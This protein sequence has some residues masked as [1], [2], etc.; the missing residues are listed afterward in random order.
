MEVSGQLYAPATL[1]TRKEPLVPIGLEA[2]WGPEPFW[3]HE[4][5]IGSDEQ[6]RETKP[7]RS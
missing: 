7:I 5:N 2:G 3:T 6:L 1:P 4:D